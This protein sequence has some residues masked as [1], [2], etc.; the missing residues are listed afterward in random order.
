M[1]RSIPP[2]GTRSQVKSARAACRSTSV[3]TAAPAE[4]S[5]RRVRTRGPRCHCLRSRRR[6]RRPRARRRRNRC[7]PC[8][9][10]GL[11]VTDAQR[12]EARLAAAPPSWM[13]RSPSRPMEAMNGMTRRRAEQAPRRTMAAARERATMARRREGAGLMGSLY[14]GWSGRDGERIGG[15][16]AIGALSQS[17]GA[18]SFRRP[19]CP[20]PSRCAGA[21]R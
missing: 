7:G 19:R 12:A 3:S 9:R 11:V 10:R 13:D 18:R 14:V 4:R 21:A 2:I 6:G 17:F 5:H 8:R 20:E 1:P 16:G 15:G